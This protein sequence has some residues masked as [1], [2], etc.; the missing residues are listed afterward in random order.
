MD[1]KEKNSSHTEEFVIPVLHCFVIQR[2]F[3]PALHR[4][5]SLSRTQSKGDSGLEGK[6]VP[7]KQI[8]VSLC[9]TLPA[10]TKAAQM[11]KLHILES[12]WSV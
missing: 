12:S 10:T 7:R 3:I 1:S 9:N 6:T 2:H 8:R 5:E 11:L 4:Y